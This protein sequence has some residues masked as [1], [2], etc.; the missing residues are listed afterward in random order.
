MVSRVL[1]KARRAQPEKKL[2][3]R[4]ITGRTRKLA[5]ASGQLSSEHGDDDADQ[6]ESSPPSAW[7]SP[8]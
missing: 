4:N 3:V 6:P 1:R 7:T 8:C 2:V 5:S